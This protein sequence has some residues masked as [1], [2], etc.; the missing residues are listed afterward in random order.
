MNT[1]RPL[2]L[3]LALAGTLNAATPS[4]APEP[5]PT[6][7]TTNVVVQS[8]ATELAAGYAAAI[9]QM[10]LKSLVIHFQGDGKVISVKGIRSAKAL[11]G[12]L[13]V[14]FSAGD[15]MA[16]NAQRIAFITDGTRTP[17]G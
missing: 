2:L 15:M 16:M 17:Q 4:A 6:P 3:S 9:S 11:N 5:A 10:S 12:V 13:L 7:S 1:M 8:T 14:T